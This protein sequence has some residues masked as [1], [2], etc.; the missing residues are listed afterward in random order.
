[1]SIHM[2][3]PAFATS[4]PQRSPARP[5]GGAPVAPRISLLDT[6]DQVDAIEG[7]WRALDARTPEATGFQ[8][9]EWCCAW[10]RAEPHARPG[11]WRIV[12]VWAG[13]D[14]VCLLPLQHDRRFGVRV[15]RWLG[16]PWT[17]YGDALAEPGPHRIV[18]LA[19]AW[20][21]VSAWRDVD[22]IKLG[23][24]RDEAALLSLP[25]FTG[26]TGL[27]TESA[28]VLDLTRPARPASK[29]SLARRR[30]KLEAIAPVRFE[31]VTDAG[32]RLHLVE[33]AI[34]LKRD[35][36][37]KRHKASSGL[38]H[39]NLESLLRD[40]ARGDRLIVGRLA[41]GDETAALELGLDANGAFRSLLGCHD[42]RFAQGSP[43]HLLIGHMVDWC[44]ARGFS[45]Y[46]LMTPAD[47]YKRQWA[48]DE[49]P[50]TDHLVAQAMRG[51]AAAAYF[52]ARPRLKS[53]HARMPAP[54]RQLIAKALPRGA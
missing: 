26:R 52:R 46:D 35:W 50:V 44:R 30:R 8:S 3:Q 2:L 49:M 28:P 17:Q 20:R 19:A 1:M 6:L 23:R 24:V 25:G 27:H 43:G 10:M 22:L 53:L 45:A 36:L 47:E 42:V 37:N 7:A 48:N 39:A 4:P 12:A 9:F 16:E 18:H 31:I 5:G 15:L 21:E 51:R 54:C 32:A 40:L 33:E 13:S 38:W 14:L 34:G 11:R 41:V 29:G